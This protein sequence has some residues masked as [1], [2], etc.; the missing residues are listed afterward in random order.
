MA[1]SDHISA[2][3]SDI[4]IAVGDLNRIVPNCASSVCPT[5]GIN[6]DRHDRSRREGRRCC[7]CLR[8]LQCDHRNL[9]GLPVK[10]QLIHLVGMAAGRKSLKR[11]LK[12]IP[13]LKCPGPGCRHRSPDSVSIL[14][15][16]RGPL[17]VCRAECKG[18]HLAVLY[19]DRLVLRH[20]TGLVSAV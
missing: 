20:R 4:F 6:R 19:P 7:H 10:L 5:I 12:G 13:T 8:V 11:P 15:C 9:D 18:I 14:I 1:V 17:P 3:N 2:G 16:V